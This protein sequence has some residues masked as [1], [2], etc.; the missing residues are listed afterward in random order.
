MDT[1][2]NVAIQAS[3]G[4]G[5]TAGAPGIS[6]TRY[7]SITNAPKIDKLNGEYHIEW[8]ATYLIPTISF[9]FFDI[10][11]SVYNKIMEW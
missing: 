2:G 5:I 9:N 11:Q 10:S 3:G 6:V 4:G 1:K 7:K 8:G